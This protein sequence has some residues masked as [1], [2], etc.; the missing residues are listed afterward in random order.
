[1]FT[2]FIS[3]LSKLVMSKDGFLLGFGLADA[4]CT[5]NAALVGEMDSAGNGAEDCTVT[6]I[7]VVLEVLSP[8]RQACFFGIAAVTLPQLHGRSRGCGHALSG[9]P[10]FRTGTISLSLAWLH[11]VDR[12]PRMHGS[13]E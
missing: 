12:W 6:S 1:M 3:I 2:L 13:L 9:L 7:G 8:Q 11:F 5:L 4:F 10:G